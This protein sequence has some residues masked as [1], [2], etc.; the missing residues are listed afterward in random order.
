[1]RNV[2]ASAFRYNSGNFALVFAEKG[3]NEVLEDLR[4]DIEDFQFPLH[5]KAA[6]NG[7]G[8]TIRYPSA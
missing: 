2:N 5:P 8:A 3:R 4:A 6:A 1:L 7:K